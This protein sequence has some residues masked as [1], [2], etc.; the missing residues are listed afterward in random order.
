MRDEDRN[1]DNLNTPLIKK[2]LIDTHSAFK[3]QIFKIKDLITSRYLPK[4]SLKQTNNNTYL[5][6]NLFLIKNSAVKLTNSVRKKTVLISKRI[7]NQEIELKRLYNEK[8][9]LDQNKI[10]FDIIKNQQKLIENYKKNNI[11]LKINLTK[12]E[13]KLKENTITKRKFLVNNNEL[14]STLSRYIVHNKKLQENFAQLKIEYSKTSFTKVQI[15]ELINKIKFYQEENMRLS[16]EINIAQKNYDLIKNNLNEVEKEK[17]DIFNQIKELNNSLTKNNIVSNTFENEEVK[18]D[19]IKPDN[20]KDIK[21]INPSKHKE[22]SEL[23][24]GLGD[25][26]D[27]INNIFK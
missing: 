23:K 15:V 2:N 22:I 10:Q 27:E 8:K 26:D 18:E 14:K 21:N 5:D 11:E 6:A 12:V 4:I 3:I 16:S 7:D 1:F 24:S 17:H 13:K 25:L 20:S 9:L 19:C